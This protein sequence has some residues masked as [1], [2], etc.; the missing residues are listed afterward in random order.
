M[1]GGNLDAGTLD[2]APAQASSLRMV[3]SLGTAGALAGLLIVVVF[4]VTLAPIEAHKAEVL[5]RA[6]SEVLNDPA[7]YE[8][9][10]ATP[11]DVFEAPPAGGAERNAEKIYVGLDAKG[12]ATGVGVKAAAAGFQDVITLIYGFDPTTG[13]LLGMKVLESKE[14][15]GLGDKIEKD[16]SF[17]AQFRGA[18]PPLQAVKRVTGAPGEIDAIT[19]AT[20][21]S[22]AVVRIINESLERLR[23]PIEA[24]FEETSP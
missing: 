11:Q 4:T 24:H 1:S 6:V 3:A 15:P 13:K 18:T 8:T 7:S 10:Y 23:T 5:K 17:V 2:V 22:R 19:G 12:R 20:I 16:L 9:L 21:S 14:T